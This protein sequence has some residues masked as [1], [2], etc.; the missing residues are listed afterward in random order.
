VGGLAVLRRLHER[1]VLADGDT[2][3][4]AFGL[5]VREYRGLPAVEHGGSLAGFRTHVLRFPDERMG[6]IVLCNT[7]SA[8]PS[9]LARSVAELF[10]GDALRPLPPPRQAGESGE[11]NRDTEPPE[12]PGWSDAEQEALAGTYYSDELDAS[13]RLEGEGD[14]LTLVRDDG[15]RLA[16]RR[17]GADEAQA[18]SAVLRFVREAGPITGFTLDSGR[19]RGIVFVRRA[20][21]FSIR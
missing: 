9:Q 21:R 2:L 10:L 6:V 4:Y 7:S 8:N 19:V 14:G 3:D 16:L 12:E 17:A 15:Q 1:G 5:N 13:Y 11:A 20:S 18:G